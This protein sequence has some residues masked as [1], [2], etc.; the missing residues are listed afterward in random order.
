MTEN[1]GFF[2][3]DSQRV[4]KLYNAVDHPN[5]ALLCD[6]GN[7]L[8]ADEDPAL[9][10]ARVAPYAQYV[11][12]K[13]F[14]WKSYK[15]ADPGEGAFRTRAGNFLRG[16][17]VGHGNVPVQQC[18]HILKAAGF[19]GAIAIEFEGVETPCTALRIGL[20]QPAALLGP[21]VSS[22]T[23]WKER[24]FAHVRKRHFSRPDLL[25]HRLRRD[26]RRTSPAPRG[27]KSWG[28]TSWT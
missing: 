10:V 22:P 6:M 3:Q 26:H 19:D 13:D 25:R 8:C 24:Q 7:F 4:E 28:P 11:H 23:F 20:C 2:S 9:A 21:G 15:D 5:F 27:R 17:I 12:A 14:I 16:T 18:L 1:H